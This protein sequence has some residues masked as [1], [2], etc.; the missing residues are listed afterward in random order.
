MVVNFTVTNA[1]TSYGFSGK[2]FIVTVYKNET[3]G[4]SQGTSYLTSI[5]PN[6][7]SFAL[8]PIS[9]AA[10]TFTQSSLLTASQN[11][12]SITFALLGNIGKG[13]KIMC[14]IPKDSYLFAVGGN[15]TATLEREDSSYYYVAVATVCG[16]VGCQGYLQQFGLAVQNSYFV[17][18]QKNNVIFY[19][20]YDG[21]A[22]S[23]SYVIVTDSQIPQPV[24]SLTLARTS[25]TG[26]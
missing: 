26:G 4:T 15:S 13:T 25:S 24:P 16:A 11:T 8:L 9:P 20:V 12:L 14:L 19:A 2:G 6:L 21:L 1:W 7:T 18:K 23:E 22:V 3:S 5:Y 17:K 10:S